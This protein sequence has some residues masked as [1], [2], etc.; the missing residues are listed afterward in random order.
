M[1]ETFSFLLSAGKG[2]RVLKWRMIPRHFSTSKP[3]GWSKPRGQKNPRASHRTA[4]EKVL[5]EKAWM[6]PFQS[7]NPGILKRNSPV[8]AISEQFPNSQS[9][10][11]SYTILLADAKLLHEEKH[12]LLCCRTLA[13]L[14][15]PQL[16]AQS[17]G[18]RLQTRSAGPSGAATIPNRCWNVP[19][20][21]GWD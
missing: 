13:F 6:K 18:S 19:A 14:L 15:P 16:F 9:S 10:A 4:K 1:R 5:G 8:C 20:L 17:R 3:Q 12:S 21:H 7:S 2:A 11:G